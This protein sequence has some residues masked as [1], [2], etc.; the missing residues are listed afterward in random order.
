MSLDVNNGVTTGEAGVPTAL[1]GAP[2]TVAP[3]NWR[4]TNWYGNRLD[5]GRWFRW[6]DPVDFMLYHAARLCAVRDR[7][8][9]DDLAHRSVALS[10]L[11]SRRYLNRGCWRPV[12]AAFSRGGGLCRRR[13]LC[14]DQW[15]PRDQGG[16]MGVLVPGTIRC[17]GELS[18]TVFFVRGCVMMKVTML[19]AALML[20]VWAGKASAGEGIVVLNVATMSCGLCSLTVSTAV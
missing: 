5:G 14:D 3:Q 8:G 6:R 10:A 4:P 15:R 16:S 18:G 1:I 11:F 20:V 9:M 7:R 13:I 19:Y 12:G 2:Q 17:W